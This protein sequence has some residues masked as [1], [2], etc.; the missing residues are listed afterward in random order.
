[1]LSNIVADLE[2]IPFLLKGGLHS[3][4]KEFIKEFERWKLLLE[5][6]GYNTKSIVLNDLQVY[7][8]KLKEALKN[9]TN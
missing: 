4:I 2:M 9:G 5:E 6:D 1:M 8:E 7:I 3:F